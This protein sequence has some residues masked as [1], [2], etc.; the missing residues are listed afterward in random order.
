MIDITYLDVEASGSWSK[1]Q[2]VE[3]ALKK[4]QLR[5]ALVLRR[6]ITELVN[7]STSSN[8]LPAVPAPSHIV[9]FT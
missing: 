5:V 8:G 6:A 9:V 1:Y 2:V 4:T 3:V 7:V